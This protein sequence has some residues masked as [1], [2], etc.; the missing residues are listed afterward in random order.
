MG[1]CLG[2]NTKKCIIF[3]EPKKKEHQTRSA[4]NAK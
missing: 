2:E 4:I 1:Q 3:L